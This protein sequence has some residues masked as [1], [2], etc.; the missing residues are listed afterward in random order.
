MSFNTLTFQSANALSIP[1]FAGTFFTNIITN[2]VQPFAYLGYDA[3]SDL[4]NR[5]GVERPPRCPSRC[6]SPGGDQIGSIAV[7]PSGTTILRNQ[8]AEARDISV[9]DAASGVEITTIPGGGFADVAVDPTG[10]FVYAVSETFPNARDQIVVSD[11]VTNTVVDS[12]SF[13]SCT[14][15]RGLTFDASGATLYAACGT[16]ER[17]RGHRHRDAHRDRGAGRIR[18]RRATSP[19][20]RRRVSMGDESGRRQRLGHR[21]RYEYGSRYDPRGRTG[22]P[23]VG[24]FIGPDFICGNNLVEPG[25]GCDDGNVRRRRRL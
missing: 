4:R 15:L 14:F 7:D 13:P 21:H 19:H 8:D 23:S 22:R 12:Q 11:T 10:A 5:H 3:G 24:D 20:S 25:E 17:G 1:A 16:H 18:D 6:P 9:I 2:P